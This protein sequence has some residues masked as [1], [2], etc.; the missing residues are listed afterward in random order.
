M[1]YDTSHEYIIFCNSFNTKKLHIFFFMLYRIK[2]YDLTFYIILCIKLISYIQLL[3]NEK[4]FICLIQFQNI[5]FKL[6]E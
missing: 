3:K 4:Q 2:Y 5:I 6:N 1:F